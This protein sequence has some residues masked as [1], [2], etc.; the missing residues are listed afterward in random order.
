MHGHQCLPAMWYVLHGRPG[1]PGTHGPL[2]TI[3]DANSSSEPPVTL[4]ADAGQTVA[5]RRTEFDAYHQWLGIPP[6]EQPPHHYRLLGLKL[7]ENDPAVIQNAADR[8]MAHLRTFQTG[9]RAALSQRLLGEVATAKL[10]LLKAEKKAAYDEQ[11]R[12]T[13]VAASAARSRPPHR[14]PAA[15]AAGEHRGHAGTFGPA[16]ASR[17]PRRPPTPP[18][19]TPCSAA[20][21][22]I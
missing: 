9:K 21:G 20:T 17:R 13:V 3:A 16:A 8:Q 6:E 22:R 2:R 4:P 5:A 11:L 12:R 7:F 15:E 14:R 19:P 10:C 18:P 1:A